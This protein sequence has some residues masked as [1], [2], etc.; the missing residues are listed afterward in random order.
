[1]SNV[2][3][4]HPKEQQELLVLE[5]VILPAVLNSTVVRSKIQYASVDE[6][7]EK[8]KQFEAGLQTQE[9]Y[10]IFSTNPAERTLTL[11][12]RCSG[13]P[14]NF[15]LEQL[16]KLGSLY[17]KVAYMPHFSQVNKVIAKEMEKL[18]LDYQ[19]I[20]YVLTTLLPLNDG[21]K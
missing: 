6:M 12:Y 19:P 10:K 9:M 11:E 16:G 3:Q 18:K 21:L 17:I 14:S 5:E 4:N 1:M 2:F 7:L 13:W 8:R 20:W 15:V